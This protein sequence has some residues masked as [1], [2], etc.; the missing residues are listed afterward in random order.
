MSLVKVFLSKSGFA[1]KQYSL[2]VILKQ[3]LGVNPTFVEHVE[4][5]SVILLENMNRVLLKDSFF[6]SFNGKYKKADL[7]SSAT[8]INSKFGNISSLYGNGSYEVSN[9]EI[10]INC[11]IIASTFFMLSRWEESL[12]GERDVHKRFESSNSMTTKLGL[13]NRPIVN[14]YTE[15]LWNILVY[16]GYPNTRKV[17]EFKIIPTHDVDLPK[18]WWSFSQFA[19]NL[20]GD[21]VKRRSLVNF[22]YTFKLGLIKLFTGVDPFDTFD[23]LMFRSEKC[24]VK[25]Y[26]F[27][28]SGGTSKRD[29]FYKVD[30]P[31]IKDLIH[32]IK[33]RQHEIGFHPSYNAY[34]DIEQFEKEQRKLESVSETPILFGRQHFLRFENPTTWRIW[35]TTGMKWDSTMSFADHVGF[36]CGVCYPFTVFDIIE[37]KELQLI[38]RPLI[39]M[40]GSLVTYQNK[41]LEDQIKEIREL[42]EQVLK[43]NGDFVFLWHN[44]AFSTREWRSKLPLLDELYRMPK[45]N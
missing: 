20:V 41:E 16:L 14:E 24:G 37:R 27:F 35:D 11:D 12:D 19:K 45:N 15:F 36:R 17:R 2:S 13:L 10:V 38:E 34:N 32:R 1:E 39:I 31:F 23:E 44:S 30:H 4:Q 18:M 3:F 21:L 6:R 25:S 9:N 26:F 43:Y 7:P 22:T 28:M 40:D 5:Y 29:N 8:D 42:K 33:S